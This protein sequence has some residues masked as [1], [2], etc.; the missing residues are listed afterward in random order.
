MPHPCNITGVYGGSPA[1]SSFEGVCDEWG[2]GYNPYQIGQS[3]FYG[4]GSS[5]EVDTTRPFTVVTSFPA[6]KNGKLL[7]MERRWVQDGR[8]IQNAVVNVEGREERNFIND[9]YCEENPGG[10][11]RFTELGGMVEMGEAMSRGMVLAMS[12]WY[13]LIS[14]LHGPSLHT[15]T[16]ER[17]LIGVF[18]RW[19]QGGFMSWLDG[20]SSGSGP[21]DA[22]EGDPA[23]I[24]VKQPD[25]SLTFSELKWGE[26]GST[27]DRNQCAADNC[28]RALRANTI[29]GRLEE[30][31]AFC[32]TFTKTFVEDVTLVKPYAAAACTGDIVSR[33]SSACS[34]LS[35][36]TS[37]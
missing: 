12:I 20:K 35:K 33:V 8:V 1:E 18:D 23:V 28:L 31:Q 34:C 24:K 16:R 36:P 13:V 14:S 2:C 7:R 19:D 5:F 29:K 9:D 25:V 6:D 26:I 32:S 11:R 10:T 15:R 37:T 21:C 22:T 30:S 17:Q 27:Y 4:R 3:N